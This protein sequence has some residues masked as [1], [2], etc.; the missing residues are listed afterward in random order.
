MNAQWGEDAIR[1]LDNIDVCVA[2]A[3]DGG[4]VT[5]I[6]TDVPGRGLTSISAAVKDM[7][8][9]AREGTLQPNEMIGGTFT[10]SNLGMFGVSHFTSIINPPQATAP[11]PHASLS[12]SA[13]RH[14]SS[15]SHSSQGGP[16]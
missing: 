8:G 10:V 2:V 1:Y 11:P 14:P 9:R 15:G 4:L 12:L 7:A 3:T 6:V 5:P 16:C 13:G